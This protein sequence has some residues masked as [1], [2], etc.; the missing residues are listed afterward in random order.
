MNYVSLS[1]HFKNIFGTKVYKLS[2]SS[3]CSCPNR[4]GT[5][6]AGGCVFCSE[7]GSGDFAA[8]GGLD[9]QIAAAKRLVDGKFPKN[10]APEERK[11]FA[12]FQSFT[13]TYG[14][15]GELERLYRKTLEYPEIVGLSIGTRPDCLPQDIVDMLAELNKI[16]PVWVELGLQ[17]VNER[18]ASDMRRGYE[19]GAFEDAYARLKAA[20]LTVIVHVIL[21]L[22]G[23]TE[24][25]MLVTVRYLAQLM[26]TL[27]GIKL[28]LL[29][30][31][32]GTELGRRY[33]AHEKGREVY[34]AGYFHIMSLDEYCDVVVKCLKLLPPET[35]IHRITGDPPKRLLI[36]PKWCADKKRVLNALRGAIERATR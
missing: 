14:D 19:L 23:E 27:D 28:Q 15:A 2:L 33:E 26:P 16:K 10:I 5:V 12:Y 17:T 31:L 11:Y 20:G 21:G 13:N 6:G 24:E 30:I 35:V 22:P 7:G 25:D 29:H 32:K 8:K 34:P 9:E 1:D 18:T 3:G 36:E 4:D